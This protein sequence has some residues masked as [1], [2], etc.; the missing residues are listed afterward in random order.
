MYYYA[1]SWEEKG[2]SGKMGEYNT[3]FHTEEE[4]VDYA[5]DTLAQKPSIKEVVLLSVTKAITLRR[6]PVEIKN[7]T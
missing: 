3:P 4:A 5:A 6:S 7:R 1:V 2:H